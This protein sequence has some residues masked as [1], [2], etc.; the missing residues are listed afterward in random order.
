[1]MGRDHAALG[2]LVALGA[3]HIA[4]LDP[5]ATLAAAGTVA[6]SALLPDIDEPGSTVAHLAEPFTGMVAWVTKRVA[7]GHRC[8]THS[9]LAV[10]LSAAVAWL[11]LHVSLTRGVP[12][13]VILVG[14]AYAICFR[15]LIPR[16][17][18]PG[19]IVALVAAAAATWATWRYVGVG[20]TLWAVPLGVG[21][22]LVGDV[23]TSSGVPL[24]WPH[25]AHYSLPI[26]G[27]TNSVKEK[28]AGLV[29]LGLVVLLAWAPA[30]AVIPTIAT[31]RGALP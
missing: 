7:G 19:H 30:A 23:V 16:L 6:G 13:A 28:I 8:A 5:A 11:L 22:H 12:A 26:L 15:S 17:V 21:L 3:A 10:A 31:V 4:G 27:H 9:L 20:W 14:L 18:R 25:K 2:A 29:M 1:M 24:L